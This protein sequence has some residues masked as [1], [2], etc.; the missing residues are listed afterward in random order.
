MTFTNFYLVA[1]LTVFRL[2]SA[3]VFACFVGEVYNGVGHHITHPEILTNMMTIFH[4]SWFHGWINV[5][6][7]SS[8]KISIGLFLL[9]LVQ[10]KWYKVNALGLLRKMQ[11]TNCCFSADLGCMGYFHCDIHSS[12]CGDPVSFHLER[13]ILMYILIASS[14]FQCLPINAAWDIMLRFDP[15]TR[16]YSTEIFRSIGLFNGGKLLILHN[17]PCLTNPS[18]HQHIHRLFIRNIANPSYPTIANQH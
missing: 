18:S 14:V 8:V 12:I 6:G 5:I 15:N 4:W 13:L 9:R 11:G 7:I 10:G 16:C 1:E 17:Q 3:G 2:C